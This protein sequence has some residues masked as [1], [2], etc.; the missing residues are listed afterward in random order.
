MQEFDWRR[1]V[2]GDTGGSQ[3]ENLDVVGRLSYDATTTVRS[4]C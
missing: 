2:R 4:T 1:E 3:H